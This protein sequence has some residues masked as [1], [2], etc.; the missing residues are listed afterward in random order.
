MT[1]ENTKYENDW[2]DEKER[3]AMTLV[4]RSWAYKQE[5]KGLF[6]KRIKVGYRTVYWKRSELIA[7]KKA[8][9]QQSC[10]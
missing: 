1:E 5:K 9:E 2:V 3:Y 8:K 10:Q 4:S 7:W 6:P